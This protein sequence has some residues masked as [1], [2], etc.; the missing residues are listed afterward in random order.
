MPEWVE[1]CVKGVLKNP[2]FK[3]KKGRTKKQSAWAIC[4]DRYKDI[5][6][7]SNKKNISNNK[8]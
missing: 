6:A 1:N 8:G 4:T 5:Q 2:N 3:S 7:L